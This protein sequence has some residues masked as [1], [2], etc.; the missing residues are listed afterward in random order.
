[1]IEPQISR[2]PFKEDVVAVVDGLRGQVDQVVLEMK[3]LER[4]AFAG[5]MRGVAVD[6]LNRYRKEL[7]Y[8]QNHLVFFRRRVMAHEGWRKE[9][10]NV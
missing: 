8:L 3:V 4:R 5:G 1:M 7:S 10:E 6:C 2:V 9:E